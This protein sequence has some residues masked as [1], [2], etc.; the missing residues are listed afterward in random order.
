MKKRVPQL[1]PNSVLSGM[2]HPSIASIFKH[3]PQFH[4]KRI[5]KI[6][7]ITRAY[8]NGISSN[9]KR[10]TKVVKKGRDIQYKLPYSVR[11]SMEHRLTEA[12][13]LLT[14]LFNVEACRNNNNSMNERQKKRQSASVDDDRNR[15]QGEMIQNHKG[16][17]RYDSQ[18]LCDPLYM[19]DVYVIIGCMTLLMPSHRPLWDALDHLIERKG[20]VLGQIQGDSVEPL[21][22]VLLVGSHALLLANRNFLLNGSH[23]DAREG[24]R[25]HM[26][27][28]RRESASDDRGR[29][30]LAVGPIQVFDHLRKADKDGMYLTDS[31]LHKYFSASRYNYHHNDNNDNDNDGG[32]HNVHHRDELLQG[33]NRTS[34]YTSLI[35]DLGHHTSTRPLALARIFPYLHDNLMVLY[36]SMNQVNH[37]NQRSDLNHQDDHNRHN[38]SRNKMGGESGRRGRRGYQYTVDYV[39]LKHLWESSKLNVLI[40]S[41]DTY[42]PQGGMGDKKALYCVNLD[43]IVSF[44]ATMNLLLIDSLQ[45]RPYQMSYDVRVPTHPLPL[46]S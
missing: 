40:G 33:L 27:R 18:S 22:D 29:G 16:F 46:P 38:I 25:T 35:A 3:T 34:L 14:E 21:L 32:A 42:M 45:A 43:S 41:C 11:R 5:A 36:S 44:Y 1:N 20:Q 12:A 28:H 13:S 15:K 7:E 2:F 23:I 37:N 24:R 31:N 17:F 10:L 39:Q 6:H 9:A 26:N 30:H 4:D 19:N 8:I